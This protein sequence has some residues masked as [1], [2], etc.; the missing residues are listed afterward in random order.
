[1]LRHRNR[2]VSAEDFEALAVEAGG[3]A[4]ARALPLLH[5]EH[6]GAQVPGVVTVV[7]VPD[8]DEVPPE[9]SPE[10][11]RHVAGYLDRCR[12]LGCEVFV[13]RPDFVDVCVD[14]CLSIQPQAPV[15]VSR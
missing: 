14:T 6:L 9:A 5:P 11:L 2:A 8:S 4:R 1:M 13:C 15:P 12:L 3:V 10:L 7:I